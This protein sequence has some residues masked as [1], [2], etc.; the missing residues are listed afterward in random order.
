M[1]DD[2]FTDEE[3]LFRNI[4]PSWWRDGDVVS[5]QA[6]QANK[7]HDW[8]LSTDRQKV[9]TTAQ[10]SFT[11]FTT[12]KPNGFGR[13]SVGVCALSVGEVRSC[14]REVRTDPVAA[15]PPTDDDPGLPANPAHA[16]V[17]HEQVRKKMETTADE[18][19]V[20]ANKRG[21]VYKLA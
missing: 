10:A 14:G 13:Q 12:A 21:I 2:A 11:L 15:T 19:A 17:P 4:S 3:L 9:A 18:L 20:H 6:F 16:V 8:C 7:N 1:A 5:A